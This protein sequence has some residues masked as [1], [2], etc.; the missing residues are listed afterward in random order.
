MTSRSPSAPP[1]RP[2]CPP[3]LHRSTSPDGPAFCI[4]WRQRRSNPWATRQGAHADRHPRG[5]RT[6]WARAPCRLCRPLDPCVSSLGLGSA[7]A[8]CPARHQPAKLNVTTLLP[9]PP[10]DHDTA[11]LDLTKEMSRKMKPDEDALG[12]SSSELGYRDQAEF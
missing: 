9:Q 11:Y 5:V 2:C 1:S 8:A 4:A 3:R 7:S 12:V 10:E 6:P